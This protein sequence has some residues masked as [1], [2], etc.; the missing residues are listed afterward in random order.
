MFISN[1]LLETLFILGY[2]HIAMFDDGLVF[3][4]Q[5]DK[6]GQATSQAGWQFPQVPVSFILLYNSSNYSHTTNHRLP[7]VIKQLW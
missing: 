4:E 2:S 5:M 6:Q 3:V 1:S 7:P